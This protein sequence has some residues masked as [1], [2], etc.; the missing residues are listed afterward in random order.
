MTKRQE[1]KIFNSS[2]AFFANDVQI[3][4]IDNNI[5]NDINMLQN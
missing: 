1:A 3:E 2:G 4:K 5:A